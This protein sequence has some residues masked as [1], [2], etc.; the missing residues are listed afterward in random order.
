MQIATS[1]NL[2]ARPLT[3]KSNIMTAQFFDLRRPPSGAELEPGMSRTSVVREL[4]PA[5]VPELFMAAGFALVAMLGAACHGDPCDASAKT[6]DVCNGE[7]GGVAWSDP[8]YCEEYVYDCGSDY[9]AAAEDLANCVADK[10]AC[11]PEEAEEEC[12]HQFDALDDAA[13]DC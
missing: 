11:T 1:K 13:V 7:W 3:R 2:S 9:E 12:S 4:V 5:R 10:E 6:Y 8:E